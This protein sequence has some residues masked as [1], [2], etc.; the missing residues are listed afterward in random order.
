ME[1]VALSGTP[2]EHPP[3]PAEAGAGTERFPARRRLRVASSDLPPVVETPVPDVLRAVRRL[4]ILAARSEPLQAAAALS[5]ADIAAELGRMNRRLEHLQDLLVSRGEVATVPPV[6]SAPPAR[7]EPGSEAGE[8]PAP[9]E[10][11]LLR[12]Q[13]FHDE[14]RLMSDD[15]DLHPDRQLAAFAA[16]GYL[17]QFARH[18][19][20]PFLLLDSQGLPMRWQHW[21]GA[22]EGR[23]LAGRVEAGD[24]PG[25]MRYSPHDGGADRLLRSMRIGS[26]LLLI[27][28][29]R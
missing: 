16:S 11:L 10:E 9:L 23:P 18:L 6:P 29:G 4:R 25:W 20:L 5:E 12:L 8:T 15:P 7:P 17:D 24:R 19:S 2:T 1:T 26:G 28:E 3:R 21:P 22:R 14:W 13:G 27:D